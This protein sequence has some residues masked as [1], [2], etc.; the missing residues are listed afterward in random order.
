MEEGKNLQLHLLIPRSMQIGHFSKTNL[1]KK[2]L[3]LL[4]LCRAFYILSN[5]YFSG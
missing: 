5:R 4:V 3:F 2:T 1:T